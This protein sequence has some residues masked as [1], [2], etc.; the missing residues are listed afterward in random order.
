[1]AHEGFADCTCGVVTGRDEDGV[2]GKAIRKD[3]QEL[4]AAVGKWAHNVGGQHIP[5]ALGLDGAGHP[6]VVAIIGAQLT[7]GA[8][9]SGLQADAAAG[10][11]GV[12]VAEKLPQSMAT[13]VGSG[14][15]LPGDLPGFVFISQ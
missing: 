11:V 5:R 6:L 1:M 2:L 13:K 14:M 8:T 10:F 15:E 3:N 12:S 4:V 7:L 9:L